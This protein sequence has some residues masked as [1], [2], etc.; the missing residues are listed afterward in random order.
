MP[1]CGR[2]SPARSGN[3]QQTAQGAVRRRSGDLAM[4]QSRALCPTRELTL[5]KR[6]MSQGQ[7]C[8]P[9]GPWHGPPLHGLLHSS[10]S[11]LEM[12]MDRGAA[13]AGGRRSP[14][15]SAHWSILT[16]A[17]MGDAEVRSQRPR[18]G[19]P[20]PRP[21][22][23]AA[24]LFPPRST[25]SARKGGRHLGGDVGIGLRAAKSAVMRSPRAAASRS[26]SAAAHAL[27]RAV[28]GRRTGAG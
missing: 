18:C 26:Q 10:S 1:S 8:G 7:R 11:R 27:R 5:M 9:R 21:A 19:P 17:G 23:H 4:R 3:G 6:V 28:E 22:R 12:R 14:G 15:T 13:R 24:G 2:R 25:P 16:P 20:G